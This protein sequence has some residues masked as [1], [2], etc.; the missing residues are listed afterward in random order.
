M[1][2]KSRER[3]GRITYRH[4][5]KKPLR[6]DEVDFLIEQL[7]SALSFIDSLKADLRK[8][9]KRKWTQ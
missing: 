8:M 5:L 4:H 6:K 3:L 2:A 1:T 9:G 7:I